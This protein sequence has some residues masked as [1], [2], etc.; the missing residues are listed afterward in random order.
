MIDTDK[1]EKLTSQTMKVLQIL[2]STFCIRDTCPVSVLEK[3]TKRSNVVID[4]LHK[5]T[6]NRSC[7]CSNTKDD[8]DVNVENI[9]NNNNNI[10]IDTKTYSSSFVSDKCLCHICYTLEDALRHFPE[11]NNS[12][13][14]KIIP[15][16]SAT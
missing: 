6:I 15:I 2:K 14:V 1:N 13:N 4:N 8:R 10:I 11:N 5:G 3:L 16:Q 12:R 9:E 7:D